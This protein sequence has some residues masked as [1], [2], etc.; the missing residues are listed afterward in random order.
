MEEKKC[1][2]VWKHLTT[3]KREYNHGSDGRNGSSQG[4]IETAILQCEICSEVMKIKA[5]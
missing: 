5:E 2:H 3:I 1:S 4:C